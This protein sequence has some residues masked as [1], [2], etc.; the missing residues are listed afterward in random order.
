MNGS[1]IKI[2]YLIT[3][4][5]DPSASSDITRI[6][7]N[8]TPG[9]SVKIFISFLFSHYWLWYL[10]HIS[11]AHHPYLSCWK[12]KTRRC[13]R[14][15]FVP[16]TSFCFSTRSRIQ[17]LDYPLSIFNSMIIWRIW[18]A[19]YSWIQKWWSCNSHILMLCYQFWYFLASVACFGILHW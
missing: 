5:A 11:N 15:I 13:K 9:L 10:G 3:P 2:L 4:V 6:F 18:V 16:V 19:A 12:C 8:I 17:I 7:S 1:F 14:H